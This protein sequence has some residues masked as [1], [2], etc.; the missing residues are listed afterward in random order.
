MAD[1]QDLV[2]EALIGAVRN[3]KDF[4][5]QGEGAL[6]AYLRQAVTNRMRDEIRRQAVRPAGK[7][8]VDVIQDPAPS[9]LESAM[10]RETF[11]R[12]DRALSALDSMEREAVVARLELGCS[13]QE[14]A[15]LLDKSTADA[16]RM[17]VTRALAKLANLMASL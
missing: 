3:L 1:T 4:S 10:G 9:P 12:Y 2:Q 8:I 5:D 17:H 15:A 6:Q 7:G 16:A 14:I 13:Y 11:G